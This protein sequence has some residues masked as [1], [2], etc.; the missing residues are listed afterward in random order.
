VVATVTLTGPSHLTVGRSGVVQADA[1]TS[2]GVSMSG[3]TFAF[4]S[5][6]QAVVSVTPAGALRAESPGTAVIS[7]TVDGVTGTLSVNATDASLTTLS[8]N[9]LPY[10]PMPGTVTQLTLVGVDSSGAPVAIRSVT[11][12]SSNPAVATVSATGQLSAIGVGTTKITVDAI[13]VAAATATMTVTV[14]P[15]PVARIA[16]LPADTVVSL[17]T[18]RKIVAIPLDSAGHPLSRVVTLTTS[19]VNAAT[20]DN[21]GNLIPNLIGTVTV[22]AT[23]DGRTAS[24]AYL[25]VPATGIYAV[26]TGGRTFDNVTAFPDTPTSDF[27][28][29]SGFVDAAGLARLAMPALVSGA[30]RVRVIETASGVYSPSNIVLRMAMAKN[31]VA[32][33]VP[34]IPLLA[35][36]LAPYD[37]TIT[38]PDTIALGDSVRVTWSFDETLEP[39][40]FITGNAP[41]GPGAHVAHTNLAPVAQVPW[42]LSSPGIIDQGV[43]VGTTTVDARGITIFRAAFLPA[44][45]GTVTF[46]VSAVG[47]RYTLLYPLLSAGNSLRKVIVK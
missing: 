22:T 14:V 37:A 36:Q 18:L 10:A 21:T 35:M 9:S 27:A 23:C 17:T 43:A 44:V 26:V 30:Y 42:S 41:N 3:K 2:A 20:I 38:A 34:P 39:F 16:M 1:R 4:S 24:Q 31:V 25:I 7:A 33:L 8:I 13:T 19:N 6:N 12:T 11:W 28:S 5:S 15:V 40:P 46:A 45:R 29:A 32:A 47:D